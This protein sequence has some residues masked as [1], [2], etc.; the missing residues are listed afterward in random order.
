MATPI[1]IN[2]ADSANNWGD[3][4]TGSP[5][6]GLLKELDDDLNNLNDALTALWLGLVK[7]PTDNL[8]A[9]SDAL[10]IV[11]ELRKSVSDT[12]VMK[13][14]FKLEVGAVKTFADSMAN[15]SDALTTKLIGIYTQSPSDTMSMSDSVSLL[16]KEYLQIGD[17]LKNYLDQLKIILDFLVEKTDSLNNWDDAVVVNR[18]SDKTQSVSDSLNNWSDSVSKNLA[19]V[20]NCFA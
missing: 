13:D 2:I 18:I 11:L 20:S 17:S 1:D 5:T 8:N 15:Y 4:L 19:E 9:W 16:R 12:M 14:F 6:E 3:S 7:R 10:R